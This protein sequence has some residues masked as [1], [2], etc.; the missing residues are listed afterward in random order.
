MKLTHK[1]RLTYLK[2][3]VWCLARK[4]KRAFNKKDYFTRK[5]NDLMVKWADSKEFLRRV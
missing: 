2:F 3:R 4:L 1:I 5:S